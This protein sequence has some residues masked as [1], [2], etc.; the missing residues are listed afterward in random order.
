MLEFSCTVAR[1][2][3]STG[4]ISV[5]ANSAE[6]AEEKAIKQANEQ[7]H[8]VTWLPTTLCESEIGIVS[9]APN[10]TPY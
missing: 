9:V 7:P 4:Q 6:E 3:T 1:V 2:T 5:Q 10:T 8:T